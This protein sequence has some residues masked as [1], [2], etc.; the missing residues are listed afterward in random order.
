MSDRLRA[1]KTHARWLPPVVLLGASTGGWEALTTIL[2]SFP[3]NAPPVVCVQ[4]IPAAFS[5]IFAQQLGL[6]IHL[7]VTEA[8]SDEVVRPGHVYL[9]PG[10]KHLLLRQSRGI[11]LQV[12][13]GPPVNRQRP[14][15]DVTFR[16]A[17]EH[18]GWRTVAA[19]LSGLGDDGVDG[20]LEIRAMGGFTLAQDQA[21]SLAG[22]MPKE[23]VRRGAAIV[24]APVERIAD[25]LLGAAA[26]RSG[27]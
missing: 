11:R 6:R 14:S 7:R 1:C 21:S 27:Q 25:I 5:A 17:A 2:A 23:A 22:D 9:A 13:E 12:H 8:R 16:S 20:L 15:I 26:R 4:H 3:A 24:V 19:I 18:I 10:G